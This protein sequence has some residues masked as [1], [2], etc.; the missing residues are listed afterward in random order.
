MNVHPF[1][2]VQEI[3]D[4]AAYISTGHV[5]TQR[6]G[7]RTSEG[8]VGVQSTRRVLVEDAV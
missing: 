4:E 1:M 3:V 5:D 7:T 6:S 8:T 2:A